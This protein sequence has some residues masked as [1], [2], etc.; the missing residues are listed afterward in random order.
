MAF[1]CR[2]GLHMVNTASF[3]ALRPS[4]MCCDILLGVSCY[5]PPAC[6]RSSRRRCV[7]RAQRG[8][9]AGHS[10][11]CLGFFVYITD[12]KILIKNGLE[13]EDFFSG[14]SN[15]VLCLFLNHDT[16]CDSKEGRL[17]LM[18]ST[19]SSVCTEIC[20]HP[21]GVL[22]SSLVICLWIGSCFMIPWFLL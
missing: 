7:K 10:S 2:L 15:D 13:R 19:E 4:V 12:L 6:S 18:P 8:H 22:Q 11:V 9:P 20:T 1:S 14:E 16:A 3:Q 5:L 17:A 21:H